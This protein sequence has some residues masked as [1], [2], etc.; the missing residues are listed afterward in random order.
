VTLRLAFMGTPDFAVPVLRALA[1]AGHDIAAVYTQTPKPAGRGKAIQTTPVHQT[2]EAL[3]LAVRTPR[4]MKDEAEI[5]GFHA[6]NL[7]AAIVVAYG[8]ILLPA[9]LEAPRLGCFNLHASLLPRWRGAAPIHRAL[10]AGDAETGVMVMRME[11]GLDTGP[12]LSAYR[13]PI[14][15][16]DTTG[17]LHDRLS[18]HGASL[19]VE[20]V[21]A[22]EAG[23]ARETP[24]PEDGV[25]YAKKLTNAETEID[26]T[27]SASQVDCHIRGLSPWPG[28]WTLI[29]GER[30]KIL[31]SETTTATGPAGQTLD[32]AL[33]IAC[34]EK[35]VRLLQLQRAGKTAQD[36]ATFLRGFPVAAHTKLGV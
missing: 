18:V 36:A 34:G 25:T 4:S 31:L 26:W 29:G 20:T 17:T 35:S 14:G 23:T 15:A 12:V 21:A 28:T 9:V 1:G 2:A 32:D 30:V 13:T 8:Q 7:D 19:M 6:L 10:M 16:K 5:A 22:L 11:A 33:T 3:G 27:R 24:Q